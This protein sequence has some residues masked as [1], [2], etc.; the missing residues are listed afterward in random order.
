MSKGVESGKW[1]LV[2]PQEWALSKVEP[3]GRALSKGSC[4]L[5]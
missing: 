5:R 4:E 2:E 3:Q 1:E